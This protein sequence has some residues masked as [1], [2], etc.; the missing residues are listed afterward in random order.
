LD[1]SA[2]YVPSNGAFPLGS[3]NSFAHK[4]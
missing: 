2:A 3:L 4:W 1:L